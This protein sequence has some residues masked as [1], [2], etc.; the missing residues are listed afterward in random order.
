[1]KQIN[2][3]SK[4]HCK[5]WQTL[6]PALS[7]NSQAMHHEEWCCCSCTVS[8]AGQE[9][10][11]VTAA[12]YR[13]SGW[14]EAVP[15]GQP[16]GSSHP[17][18]PWGLEAMASCLS[19]RPDFPSPLSP[20][21]PPGMSLAPKGFRYPLLESTLLSTA[22]G[23]LMRLLNAAHR[24]QPLRKGPSGE[25]VGPEGELLLA[26]SGTLCG[27]GVGCQTCVREAGSETL[28]EKQPCAP[29]HLGI[30]CSRQLWRKG[31][32]CPSREQTLCEP[33]VHPSR[34]ENQVQR[35]DP[36]TP[37][38]RRPG[39]CP[40]LGSLSHSA[41]LWVSTH[42]QEVHSSFLPQRYFFDHWYPVPRLTFVMGPQASA[43]ADLTGW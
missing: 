2:Y 16:T 13:H 3:L 31:Y 27:S 32:K 9:L 41:A 25:A 36:S 30:V 19:Q 33:E 39:L 12:V 26:A 38:L 24:L 28:S 8:S 20:Q 4:C 34:E 42:N 29:E 14:L 37:Q 43:V 40:G 35:R 6:I 10:L 1:M 23:S 7:Q 22:G 15:D 21:S 11:P 5:E 18:G 17:A